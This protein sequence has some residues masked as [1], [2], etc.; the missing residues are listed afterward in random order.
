MRKGMANE[1]NAAG[2][3]SE[4]ELSSAA[5]MHPKESPWERQNCL[6]LS[7]FK[8]F[9]VGQDAPQASHFDHTQILSVLFS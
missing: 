3:S 6:L 9:A 5:C 8:L 7:A 4:P 2:G 1:T